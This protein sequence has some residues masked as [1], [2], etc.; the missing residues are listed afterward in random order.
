MKTLRE[1]ALRVQFPDQ[2]WRA[3]GLEA[4]IDAA[5][6]YDDA[7]G[8]A[9]VILADFERLVNTVDVKLLGDAVLTRHD[10][11]APVPW[12]SVADGLARW[13][14]EDNRARWATTPCPD[15]GSKTVLVMPPRRVGM[16]ARYA[17]KSCAFDKTDRD[18]GGF[19]AEAFA[20]E[21]PEA[22]PLPHDPRRLTLTQAAKL[23]GRTTG[24]VR[25]WVKSGD[26]TGE[27]GRYWEAD[28][29]AVAA[30]RRGEGVAA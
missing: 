14:L 30:Q 5:A 22:K 28:V 21:I 3:M 23:V 15:C 17:C 1:W 24:T 9:D 13:S 7:A 19:W 8:C 11:R 4:G 27:M 10:L 12:W 20:E 6:A 16:S 2:G 25:G 18:D 26:L 29:Q